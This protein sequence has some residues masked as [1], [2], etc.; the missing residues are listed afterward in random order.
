MEKIGYSSSDG[1]FFTSDEGIRYNLY[2]AYTINGEN[3]RSSD[4]IIIALDDYEEVCGEV[5]GMLYGA[6]DFENYESRR[7]DYKEDIE[8]IV[9]NYE[10]IHPSIVKEI[11]KGHHFADDTEKIIDFLKLSKEEFLKSYSYLGEN[12]YNATVE[13]VAKRIVNMKGE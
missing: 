5:I 10:R 12:D 7:E 2:E 6:G 9:K 3:T 13:E 1:Y 8:R 11:G 4:L